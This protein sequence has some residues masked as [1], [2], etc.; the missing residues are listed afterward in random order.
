MEALNNKNMEIYQDSTY[1]NS[2]DKTRL[3]S[4]TKA[5]SKA[6]SKADSIKKVFVISASFVSF[7]LIISIV[8]GYTEMV[9]INSNNKILQYENENLKLTIDSLELKLEPYASKERIE[10]IASN[11]LNMI[12]PKS[13]NVVKLEKKEEKVTEFVEKDKDKKSDK[14]LISYVNGLLR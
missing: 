8:L 5:K 7:I 2:F 10:K 4:K 12:Y 3:G 14:S 13:T 11:R 6:K 1:A 9:S